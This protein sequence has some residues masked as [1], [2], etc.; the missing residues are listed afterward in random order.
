MIHGPRFDWY[1]ARDAP[2]RAMARD[3]DRGGRQETRLSRLL[4]A[5]SRPVGL[6][7][8]GISALVSTGS[9]LPGTQVRRSNRG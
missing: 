2:V 9:F 6:E 5:W 1:V 3:R 8:Q 7:A 4:P